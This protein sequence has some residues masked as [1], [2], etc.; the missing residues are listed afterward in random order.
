[1]AITIDTGL[2]VGCGCCSDVCRTGALELTDTAIVY[3]KFC[4]AC[5]SCVAVCPALAISMEMTA[6][7]SMGR[8]IPG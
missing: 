2:C 8:G 1:M 7:A 3:E 4:V 6:V 5:E